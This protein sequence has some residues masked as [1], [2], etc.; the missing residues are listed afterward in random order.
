LNADALTLGYVVLGVA[1]L[2]LLPALF[3]SLRLGALAFFSVFH[4]KTRPR[5]NPSAKI[6]IIVYAHN[7]EFFIEKVVREIMMSIKYPQELFDVVVLADNCDDSTAYIASFAGAKVL[8]RSD[9][10]EEGRHRA[11]EWAFA[12]LMSEEYDAFLLSDIEATMHPKTLGVVDAA[13]AN[14]ALAMRLPFRVIRAD[15]SWRARL[16]DVAEA[17]GKWV[18]P[19]GESV[20]GLSAGLPPTG[21]CLARTLLREIP[22]QAFS[23][24]EYEDYH[25][26]L[27]LTGERVVFLRG[28]E[29]ESRNPL[30]SSEVARRSKERENAMRSVVGRK[31]GDIVR[32]ALAFDRKAFECLCAAASPSL[33]AIGAVLAVVFGAGALLAFGGASLPSCEPLIFPAVLIMAASLLGA[34]ALAFHLAVAVF[35]GG[36]PL[37]T[38]PILLL[39]PLRVLE[40]VAGGFG[41]NADAR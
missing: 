15:E 32:A 2:A 3:A 18:V 41:R 31:A 6:A 20:L 8:E 5:E 26:R 33:S 12:K 24:A 11:L 29:L 1:A 40:N 38:W 25:V 36:L 14:G 17:A 19:R 4:L 23:T 9:R 13:L 22:Y 27:V 39:A 34:L 37:S 16:D 21:F 10:I 35:E 30:A 28:A 7:Q